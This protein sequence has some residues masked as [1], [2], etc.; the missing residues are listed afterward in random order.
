MSITT[1]EL[2][3][4]ASRTYRLDEDNPRGS[5]LHGLM[6]VTVEQNMTG[7]NQF[8][9]VF[10]PEGFEAGTSW[11]R[12]IPPYSLVI[13]EMGSSQEPNADPL[14]MIGLTSPGVETEDYLATPQTRQVV[15]PGQGIERVLTECGVYRAPWL[16]LN[17]EPEIVDRIVGGHSIQEYTGQLSWTMQIF[18]G[19]LDPREALLKIL[20][21]FTID[22]AHSVVS[23]LLPPPFL[24]SDLLVAGDQDD[25]ALDRLRKA[26]KPD[27]AWWDPAFMPST[28]KLVDPR[29]KVTS[30]ALAGKTGA[31]AGFM[32][33]CMDLV[34]HEY[35]TRYQDGKARLMYRPKP[36]AQREASEEAIARGRTL[37]D[38]S[39]TDLD[40]VVI[41][42]QDVVSA[43]LR[44][45]S[46]PVYNFF[47]VEPGSASVLPTGS[48]RAN[49]PPLYC[50]KVTDEAY[51]GR[52]GIRP[53][54]HQTPYLPIAHDEN[55]VDASANIQVMRDLT[56]ILKS[57]YDPQPV[58]QQGTITCNGRASFRPGNRLV[59]QAQ[60]ES[61]ESD[62][63]W[64][65]EFYI[66]AVHHTYDF[67]T[68]SYR[69]ANT[70]TR[71]WQLGGIIGPDGRRKLP[72]KRP[73]V[74]PPPPAAPPA[75]DADQ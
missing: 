41:T 8:S 16:E 42:S 59:W 10:A 32:A 40:D 65:R 29:L 44:Y 21:Y 28:W 31:I 39:V 75:G 5:D 4:Q 53:L 1:P 72:Y 25:A 33:S 56:F 60:I 37:F 43:T 22:H 6:A 50:G 24:L 58:L 68:G 36:F 14:V 57:W 74:E 13:I 45:G 52:W 51:L 62:G 26:Y 15:I 67:G 12:V 71:G 11:A 54:D 3:D 73:R 19:V 7:N 30:A 38:D 20:Y 66:E 55:A 70:V 23:L 46:E 27:K 9:L 61:G 18:Q 48:Y 47:Y 69:C 64:D 2:P 17:G 49:V 63:R 34:F 35:W